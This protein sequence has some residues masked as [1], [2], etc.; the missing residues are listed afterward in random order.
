MDMDTEGVERNFHISRI[1]FFGQYVLVFL[2]PVAAIIWFNGGGSLSSTVAFLGGFGVLFFLLEMKVRAKYIL[3]KKVALV[4][5]NGFFSKQTSRISYSQISY[6]HVKQTIFQRIFGYGNLEIGVPG[7]VTM[8]YF[9]GTGEV[10]INN[11][12]AASKGI[13]IIGVQNVR[14]VEALIMN[15]IH[16]LAEK[17]QIPHGTTTQEAGTSRPQGSH[18]R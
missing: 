7:E 16:R 10:N 5:E 13:V 4:I 12:A 15:R 8:H 9:A 11:D 18:R 6:L 17:T 3:V 14:T 1:R 2:L